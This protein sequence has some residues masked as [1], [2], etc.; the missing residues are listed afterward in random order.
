MTYIL[1][2]SFNSEVVLEDLAA[3]S[4]AAWVLL[5]DRNLVVVSSENSIRQ[6]G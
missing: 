1:I 4:T 3:G 5:I 6:C 2:V